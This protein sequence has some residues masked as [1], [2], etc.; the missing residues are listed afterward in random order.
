MG[1]LDPRLLRRARGVRM[2]LGADAALGVVAA[3][4]VL[5]QAALLA[6][7]AARAFGGASLAKPRAAAR[8]PCRRRS[9]TGLRGVGLRGCREARSDDRALGAATRPRR[10]AAPRPA[11]GA[12]RRAE[13]RDRDGRRHRRRR[14]RDDVRPLPATARARG[15]RAGRRA[16]LRR[17]DRP[18]LGRGDAPHAPPR[19]DL[20]VARRP[21]HRA[22]SACALA[23]ARTPREPLR[24][25]RPRAADAPCLQ[26]G[27]GADG[28]DCSGSA[29]STA[30]R[31]WA[32]SA[33][34]FSRGPCW[35][36]RRR[37]G[38]RSSR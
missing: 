32:R 10:A 16:R 12:R 1:G 8:A 23:R 33:S 22:A 21:L 25:R 31:R 38:S 27:R 3:L 18:R 4:L 7:V 26:P 36:S 24:G 30:A 11:G 14:A 19:T 28:A 5:V 20:H 9:G 13:H 34:R 37:S 29:T 2:L 35:S 6:H 17:V 15:G